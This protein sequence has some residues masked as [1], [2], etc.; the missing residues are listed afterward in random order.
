[1]TK[2]IDI[3]NG[4][5][6]VSDDGRVFISATGQELLQER[7]TTGYRRVTLCFDGKQN[8]HYVHRLVGKMFIPNPDNKPV[9]NH[10][11]GIKTDNRVKNLEWCT[12]RENTAHAYTTGLMRPDQWRSSKLTP[13]QVLFIRSCRTPRNALAARFAVH[14]STISR[15]RS[16]QQWRH[17]EI[18]PCLASSKSLI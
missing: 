14:P 1:M 4:K 18:N 6:S 11:N 7:H 17:L 3:G 13:Q 9:I 15:A 2:S 16:G 8:A 12:N 10:K 5:Y